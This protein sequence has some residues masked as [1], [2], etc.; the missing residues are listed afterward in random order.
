[1]KKKIQDI[2]ATPHKRFILSIVADYDLRRSICELVDNATDIWI[3]NGKSKK[4]IVKIDFDQNQKTITV[5]DNSGGVKET[6]LDYLISPGASSNVAEDNTIGIF[7]VGTKR[8]VIALSQDIKITTRYKKNKTFR[9][10]F[11]EIWLQDD[12]WK[13]PYYEVNSIDEGSTIIELQKLRVNIDNIEVESLEQHLS[14]TYSKFIDTKNFEMYLDGILLKSLKYENWAYPKGYNP[15]NYDGVLNFSGRKIEVNVVAG[16]T[17]ESSPASGEYG[18]YFYCNDRLI[19]RALKSPEVGYIKGIAGQPHPSSSIARIIISLKG[20][21]IDMPWNTS[22]SDINT[23]HPVFRD[24]QKWLLEIVKNYTSLSRRLAGDW[25]NTVFKFT[26]GKIDQIN[27]PDFNSTS[28]SYLLNLPRVNVKYIDTVKQKNSK[29]SKTKPWTVGLSD[30]IIVVDFISK[31]RV[32]T[33]NRIALLMLDSTIEIA[34]KEYLVHDSGKY[35]TNN[36]IQTM[37]ASRNK[38]VTEI[39]KYISKNDFSEDDWK[40]VKYYYDLRSKLVHERATVDI[41]D[42]QLNDHR[43][44]TEKILNVLF[45]LKF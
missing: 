37:F 20:A 38:V 9:V 2:D 12:D 39:Q 6:E 10:E 21:S 42:T 18:V 22:K 26:S 30:S 34:F 11:D 7:G 43:S 27:V 16:L 1:M 5:K 33:K 8:A 28:K 19:V 45:K 36:D 25:P 13:L 32:E 17:T 3:K 41:T 23:N 15:R 40:K 35:Y 24:L 44:I 31:Q 4:L 14:S 29:V